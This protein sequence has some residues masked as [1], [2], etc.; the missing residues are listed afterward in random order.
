M[1][2]GPRRNIAAEQTDWS[3]PRSYR[4]PLVMQSIKSEFSFLLPLSKLRP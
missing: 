1:I 4:K 2:F 3:E